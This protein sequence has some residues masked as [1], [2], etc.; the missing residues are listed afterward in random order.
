MSFLQ[1][2]TKLRSN[3]NQKR[4]VM[5]ILENQFVIGKH[6]KDANYIAKH[7]EWDYDVFFYTLNFMDLIYFGVVS[8]NLQITL[9]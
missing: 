6:Y 2:N 7:T 9:M 4:D 1:K 3:W 8:L 5:T